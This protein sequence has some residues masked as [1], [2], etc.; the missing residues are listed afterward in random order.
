MYTANVPHIKFAW[1]WQEFLAKIFPWFNNKSSSACFSCGKICTTSCHFHVKYAR[2]LYACGGEFYTFFHVKFI[3]CIIYHIL[4]TYI[5]CEKFL[6][7]IYAT[8]SHQ[9]IFVWK[10]HEKTAWISCVFFVPQNDMKKFS[11]ETHTL[12]V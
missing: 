7:K 5:W 6:W 1:K 3:I 4:I 2:N 9:N 8:N 11:H 10:W 12:L